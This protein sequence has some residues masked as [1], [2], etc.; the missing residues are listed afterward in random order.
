MLVITPNP[1]IMMTPN[2][3]AILDLHVLDFLLAY[4]A[5][6]FYL[7]SYGRALVLSFVGIKVLIV[8][9]LR[10]RYLCLWDPRRNSAD[11]SAY[12]A[13]DASKQSAILP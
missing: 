8:E 7:L 13:V 2:I 4:L 12:V 1:F 5:V 3:F 10:F 6:S 11:F 9:S